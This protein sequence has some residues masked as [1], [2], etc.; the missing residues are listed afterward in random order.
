MPL[1][2]IQQATDENWLDSLVYFLWLKSVY[3]HSIFYNYSLRKVSS[4][5]GCSPA[6]LA[7]HIHILSKHGLCSV[8]NGHLHLISARKIVCDKSPFVPVGISMNKAEQRTLLRYTLINRNL[9]FQCKGFC[10]K[11]ELLNLVKGVKFNYKD[12][13]RINKA[14]NNASVIETENSITDCMTLSNNKFGNLCNRSASTGTKI[15]KALNNIGVI[16]SNKRTKLVAIKQ[17][18]ASFYSLGLNG[19]FFFAPNG[20]VYQRLPNRV[21]LLTNSTSS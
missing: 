19:S 1:A 20:N 11:N 21:S 16:R 4:Q 15:Q 3:K 12:T 10:K 18:R 17:T 5:I 14:L 9:F 7:H 13:K 6:T 2:I 8:R